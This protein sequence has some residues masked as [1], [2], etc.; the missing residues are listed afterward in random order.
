MERSTRRPTR[1]SLGVPLA[2]VRMPRRAF[3]SGAPPRGLHSASRAGETSPVAARVRNRACRRSGSGAGC[4][5]QG[6]GTP[7]SV[8]KRATASLAASMN[9]SI[10]RCAKSRSRRTMFVTLPSEGSTMNRASGRSKSRLPRSC[11]RLSSSSARTLAPGSHSGSPAFPPPGYGASP[12][13]A[14]SKA[15]WTSS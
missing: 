8:R 10:S 12:A 5:R 2:S 7:F 1:Y 4:T 6:N 11:L 15:A 14:A 9:S 3:G 13:E